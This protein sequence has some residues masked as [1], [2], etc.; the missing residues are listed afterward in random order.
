[1]GCVSHYGAFLNGKND[2]S[3]YLQVNQ[4]GTFLLETHK[5]WWQWNS[6]GTWTLSSDK[7]NHY[8]LKSSSEDYSHIPV[9]IVESRN[10]SSRIMLIFMQG[11]K[12]FDCERKEIYVNGQHYTIDRDT[13]ELSN[14]CIDSI[15]ICLGYNNRENMM[16]F[17]PHYDSICSQT[18]YPLDSANNV[19]SITIPEFP[20][21]RDG[22]CQGRM[23][24]MFFLYVP[25]E[26]EAHY[27]CGK[28][29]LHDKNG[30]MIPFKR[31][32][33]RK[34][35]FIAT[36]YQLH[37]S[38]PQTE[39]LYV[40]NPGKNWWMISP[41]KRKNAEP[42]QVVWDSL[43]ISP[44]STYI[45]KSSR[46]YD[47]GGK[48]IKSISKGTWSSRGE[49][50]SLVPFGVNYSCVPNMTTDSIIEINLFEIVPLTRD[51]VPIKRGLLYVYSE[52]GT[53]TKYQ[54]DSIGH[55]KIN[56]SPDILVVFIERGFNPNIPFPKIG[57]SY[58]IVIS[59]SYVIPNVNAQFL[60]KQGD[61]LCLCSIYRD[62]IQLNSLYRRVLK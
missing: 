43:L 48:T 54:T 35:Q 46:F 62:S 14:I 41:D 55:V 21:R 37:A 6:F 38:T 42:S 18:Y 19:F 39:G 30:K 24:S 60:K 56:Y 2:N 22:W 58:N 16:F 51:T 31:Q 50:V 8:L 27:R 11:A 23:A 10:E 13:I 9:N 1:M 40:W 36:S 5:H 34:R 52:D 4:D 61:D 32:K 25:L 3:S 49:Y 15:K 29:Y 44:D 26:A 28:W 12:Y 20:Y 17:S 57:S 53:V 33:E 7:K 45:V 59:E 47:V